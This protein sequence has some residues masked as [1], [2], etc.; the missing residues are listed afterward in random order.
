MINSM[1]PASR[2]VTKSINCE[3]TS[4]FDNMLLLSTLRYDFCKCSMILKH[5]YVYAKRILNS[6]LI[7]NIKVCF[8]QM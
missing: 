5:R 7:A 8:I 6:T 4:I 1:Y 3:Y 2:I